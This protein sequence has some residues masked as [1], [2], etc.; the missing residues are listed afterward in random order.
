MTLIDRTQE[1]SR[2]AKSRPKDQAMERLPR[3]RPGVMC[4]SRSARPRLEDLEA[5]LLL[6]ALGPQVVRACTHL[7]VAREAC[8]R[9]AEAIR[10]LA[11]G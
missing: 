1:M 5:R 6:S 2:R 3:P 4:K 9:A 11:A 7:N 8:L 10:G